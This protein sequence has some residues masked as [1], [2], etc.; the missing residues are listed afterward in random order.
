MEPVT[1]SLFSV[2]VPVLSVAKI[3]IPPKSSIAER[4]LT[5]T[6]RRARLRAPREREKVMTTGRA[7]GMTETARA[8]EK[9]VVSRNESMPLRARLVT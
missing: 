1:E 7:S 2:M 5:T 8:I 9:R 4:R 3:S 6:P